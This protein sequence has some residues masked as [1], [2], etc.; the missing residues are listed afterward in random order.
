MCEHGTTVPMPLAGRV[1]DIDACLALLVATLNT[2][3]ALATVACCCGHG[4]MPGSIA[5]ADGRELVLMSREEAAAY[6]AA[7]PHTIHGEA[8]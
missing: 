4:K 1:R 8:R 7:I 2:V 6:F 5:L 3:P